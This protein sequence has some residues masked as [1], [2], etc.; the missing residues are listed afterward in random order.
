MHDP[1][2]TQNQAY[3]EHTH[4]MYE[5]SLAT[6]PVIVFLALLKFA[7]I[8]SSWGPERTAVVGV[9]PQ[10]P[11]MDRVHGDRRVHKTAIC[12]QGLERWKLLSWQN[13]K[14]RD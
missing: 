1:V 7:L 8:W 10:L 4:L 12:F 9:H 5:Q 11:G 14:K 2:L 3:R 13:K 6:V